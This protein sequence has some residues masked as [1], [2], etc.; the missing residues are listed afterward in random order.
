M[1]NAQRA[2]V[3]YLTSEERESVEEGWPARVFAALRMTEGAREHRRG[4]GRGWRL[5]GSERAVSTFWAHFER[6][7]APSERF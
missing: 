4:L 3:I 2:F 5:K 7:L 6:F 1:V